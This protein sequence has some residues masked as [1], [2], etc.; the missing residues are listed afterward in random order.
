MDTTAQTQKGTG[1]R[2]KL[3]KPNPIDVHVGSRVRLRRTLLGMSQEKLG[4]AIGLT[5]QQVQKYERGANRI[6][7]SRLFDLSRVLD[8]PVSFFFDDMSADGVSNQPID[9]PAL[10]ED[11]GAAYEPDPMAKRETLELVRAYY[12]IT[13]PAVRKRLFELTK[14]LGN[15]SEPVAA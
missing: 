4:E 6:G 5:F 1:G 2:P 13:D 15:A 12:R 11:R 8:V 14:A 7:A 10:A 9:R 3:G